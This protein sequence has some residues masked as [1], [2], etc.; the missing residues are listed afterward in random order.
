MY[1][2]LAISGQVRDLA[3]CPI[4]AISNLRRLVSVIVA[5]V[6]STTLAVIL[7]TV[8]NGAGIS[9][10]GVDPTQHA[11]VVR[12]NAVHDDVPCAAIVTAVSARACYFPVVIGVEILDLYGAEAVELD[13]LVTCFEG[14]ATVDI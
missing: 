5:G 4:R 3:V 13:D 9:V 8:C 11:S 12:N 10:V 6:P 2:P 1:I 7:A 14:T